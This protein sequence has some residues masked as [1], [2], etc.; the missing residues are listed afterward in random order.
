L[1]A[2]IGENTR[3]T[4]IFEWLRGKS[5][6]SIARN[7]VLSAGAVTNVINAWRNALD[8]PVAE[9]LRELAVGLRKLGI[10][11]TRAAL[12]AN[13]VMILNSLGVEEQDFQAFVS[14][15]YEYSKTIG[16][17]PDK[18]ADIAKQV[19]DL[20]DSVPIS[21]MPTYI[22]QMIVEK[23]N[24][25]H[26]IDELRAKESDARRQVDDALKKAEVTLNDLGEYL[27][28]KR[29][30]GKHE[31]SM[32]DTLKFVEALNHIKQL[33]F[34]PAVVVREFHKRQE[35]EIGKIVIDGL[36]IEIKKLEQERDYLIEQVGAHRQGI[37]KYGELE[38]MGFGLKKI[39]AL[40][41]TVREVA[42]ANNIL[43]DTAVDKFMKD[44][45]EQ[46]DDKLGFESTLENLRSQIRQYNIVIKRISSWIANPSD[47]DQKVEQAKPGNQF[48]GTI[49][50]IPVWQGPDK[51]K[52]V[53][54]HSISPNKDLETPTRTNARAYK[55]E[56]DEE[57]REGQ[58]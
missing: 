42:E 25:A 56:I 13:L 7:L 22:E 43:P 12:G 20:S 17:K 28:F 39:K 1:R 31:I 44:V 46:Y 33:G 47:I 55:N 26:G 2:T 29:E 3:N 19:L 10:N 27:N 57:E 4:I 40:L 14:D 50:S 38:S 18:I 30:L 34:H 11:A 6:D 58:Q 41:Q 49:D 24:L 9:A 51:N 52:V 16:L 48:S 35:V 36:R 21:K 8:Y 32:D 15:T 5:R 23:R 53:F 37:S 45:E 54:P